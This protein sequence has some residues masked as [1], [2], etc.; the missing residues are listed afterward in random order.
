LSPSGTY[1]VRDDGGVNDQD[2]YRIAMLDW[3]ACAAGGA[4]EPAARAARNAGD[5]LLERV[6]ATA[7][8]GHVLDYDDT[9][10]PG[11]VHLSA[12]V[13]PAALVLAAEL[14]AGAGAALDAYGAGFEAA[15]ALARAS[16]PQLYDG[17]WHPTAVCG[18]VGAAVAAARL[19]ELDDERAEHAVALAL[20]RA[21]GLRAGF[22]SDGKALGVG[23]AAA[24]GVHAARLAAADAR[25]PLGPVS[26]GFEQTFGGRWATPDRSAPAVREN[27]IK[28]YPCCLAT[29]S[30]I[31]AVAELRAGGRD[32][33]AGGFT[34]IV[35]PLARLAAARDDVADGLQAKFSIPYLAAYTLL[36]G[37]P[38]VAS[39]ASVR[40]DARAFARDSVVVRVDDTSGEWE[41]RIEAGGEE[42]AR[43][44]AALGSPQRPLDAARLAAKISDLAGDRLDG[45]LDDPERPAAEVLGAAGL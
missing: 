20:V 8:A 39:F 17:G 14:D 5:G 41:A 42:V 23:L 40:D 36:H 7:T 43:V 6:A 24:A 18:T 3:L 29:H 32:G 34:V 11:V 15:G 28:A 22:G 27:W 4:D 25:V 2:R 38:V 12:P 16:H 37:P 33:L 26:A 19:L 30:T 44:Q 31:E 35:H 9:Y 10:A 21:G 1:T 13:A 45:I